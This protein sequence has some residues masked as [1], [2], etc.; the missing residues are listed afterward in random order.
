MLEAAGGVNVFADINAESVQASTELI[1]ARAPEVI[2]ELRADR[3]LA[4]R[5]PAARDRDLATLASVPAVRNRPHLP[6]DAQGPRRARARAS[7]KAPNELARRAPSHADMKIL[8]SWSS[9]KDS[10]WM[11]HMLRQQHPGAVAGLLTTLNEAFDRV[12]MHAVRRTLLQA[13]ADAAGPAASRRRPSV[14]VF[15]RRIRAAHGSRRSRGFVARRLH[16]RRLRRS[17]SRR[18]A[19]LS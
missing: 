6:P 19:P 15:E 11:L 1:L 4:E 5:R 8:V 2:I 17:V 7:P 14:A 18:R 9:G 13:Q 16:A 12:A 10:A 3:H